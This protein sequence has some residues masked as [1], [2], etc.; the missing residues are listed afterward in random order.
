LA[1]PVQVECSYRHRDEADKRLLLKHVVEY[2]AT[3]E[4]DPPYRASLEP[5]G[6]VPVAGRWRA[7]TASGVWCATRSSQTRRHACRTAQCPLSG[8]D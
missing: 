1:C 6:L 8:R 7:S 2:D 3:P 4:V 5:D